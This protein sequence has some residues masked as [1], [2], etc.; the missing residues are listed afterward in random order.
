MGWEEQYKQKTV[1]FEQAA[2]QVKS[3]DFVGT[4]LGPGTCSP[5]MFHAILDR[6]Q[7]LERVEIGD[8][9]PI[10]NSKLYDT[11]FMAKI[12]GRINYSPCFGSGLTRK[13]S[14]KQLADF[15]PTAAADSGYKMAAWCDVY[16]AMVTPPT[17]RVT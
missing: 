7:E 6:Q 11:E 9:L 17:A 15:Y 5:D 4:G 12:D 10:M 8:S 2:K 3:G 1:S 13:I 14:E 16:V